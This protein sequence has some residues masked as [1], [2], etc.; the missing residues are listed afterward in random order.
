MLRPLRRMRRALLR[1]LDGV[2]R[3]LQGRPFHPAFE[4]LHICKDCAIKHGLIESE[5]TDEQSRRTP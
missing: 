5:V 3:V 4:V 1:F 2:V